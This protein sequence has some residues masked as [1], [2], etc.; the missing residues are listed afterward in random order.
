MLIQIQ[1]QIIEIWF[2]PNHEDMILN[3]WKM[4]HISSEYRAK[5]QETQK[6]RLATSCQWLSEAETQSSDRVLNSNFV[7]QKIK[8]FW[9]LKDSKL[10]V[11]EGP[12][13]WHTC[14]R[15]TAPQTP[16]LIDLT[17]GR[18]LKGQLRSLE[19]QSSNQKPLVEET[20]EGNLENNMFGNLFLTWKRV[21]S[22]QVPLTKEIM[23]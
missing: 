10:G 8:V 12:R 2:I 3:T 11:L 20:L 23:N 4:W 21:L 9:S 16:Q 19:T 13:S 14:G 22:I 6:F 1:N 5:F 17:T 7:E 15:L 18:L